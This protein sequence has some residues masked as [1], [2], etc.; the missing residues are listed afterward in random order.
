MGYLVYHALRICPLLSIYRTKRDIVNGDIY[1]LSCSS[2]MFV[3]ITFFLPQFVSHTEHS[4]YHNGDISYIYI[5]FQIESLLFCPNLTKIGTYHQT[6]IKI[7]VTKFHENS[8]I[9]SRAS[10]VVRR[11]DVKRL[12][13]IFVS[14]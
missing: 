13:V 5:R 1:S 9:W 2:L 10:H 4:M 11:T 7:S 3:S 8:S 6:L 12:A 14:P